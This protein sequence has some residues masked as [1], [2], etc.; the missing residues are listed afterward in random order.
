[1]F[2]EIPLSTRSDA[3]QSLPAAADH[4]SL[5]LLMNSRDSFNL[6]S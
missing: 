3:P 6:R 5:I 1:M 4:P 2:H